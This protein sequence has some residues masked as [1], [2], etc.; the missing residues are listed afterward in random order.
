MYLLL[1]F[2]MVFSVLQGCILVPVLFLALIN[3]ICV[4]D[5]NHNVI[6]KINDS[7]IIIIKFC[8][9]MISTL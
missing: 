5:E 4:V 9:Q 3:D 6:I 7:I 8:L 2:E 1:L